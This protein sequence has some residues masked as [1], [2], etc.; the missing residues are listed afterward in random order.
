MSAN[1]RGFKMPPFSKLIRNAISDGCRTVMLL[2]DW[3]GWG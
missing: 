1:F 2:V 3:V